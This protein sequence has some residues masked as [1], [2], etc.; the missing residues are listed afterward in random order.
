MAHVAARQL[1]G[2]AFATRIRKIRRGKPTP[3]RHSTHLT[4]SDMVG[5]AEDTDAPAGTGA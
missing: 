2:K 3:I 5:I 4:S 1:L